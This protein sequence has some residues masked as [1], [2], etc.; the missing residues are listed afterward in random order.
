MLLLLFFFFF[1]D[2]SVDDMRRVFLFIRSDS[3]ASFL[4]INCASV[5]L[6]AEYEAYILA[7][8]S[9]SSS[10]RCCNSM[11][12]CSDSDDDVDVDDATEK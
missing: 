8:F 10:I 12:L 3:W 1:D 9:V 5:T 11:V 7:N 2:D 6:L 4:P